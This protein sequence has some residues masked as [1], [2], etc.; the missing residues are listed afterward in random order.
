M[1]KFPVCLFLLFYWSSRLMASTITGTDTNYAGTE[2]IWLQSTDPFTGSE[3]ELSRALVGADGKFSFELP[4]SEVTYVYAY[5]GTDKV[6]L[7]VEPEKHYEAVLP[8]YQ[9][10][11]RSDK[12]NPFFRYT[13]AHLGISNAKHDDLNLQIRMFDDGFYPYYLKHTEK[14]FANDVEFLQLD[15]DIAQ[16]DKPFAKSTHTFFNDYRRYKYG[17]LRF[18]AYQHKSKSISDAYFKN[19]PFLANNPAYIELFNLVYEGYFDYF[20]RSDEGKQLAPAIQS[21]S[22]SAVVKVLEKDEVLQ[23]YTLLNMVLLKSLHSEFYDD[24]YSRSGML[25][26][27]DSL[28][29]IADNE[30]VKSTAMQIHSK[31][32]R[33][34]AGYT[35]PFFALYDTDSNLV[36]LEKFKGKFVYLNFCSCFSYTCLNEFVMLQNLYNKHKQYLEIVTIVPDD[37]LQ[38]VNNF[39]QRSGYQWTFLHFDNQPDVLQQYDVRAFPTYYL[40]DDEGKLSLSPAPTPAEEFEGR[41]FILLRA[42]G[43]L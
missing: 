32:T 14:V 4:V 35:P 8:F 26:L 42:K 29:A 1:N 9:P 2:I 18:V 43:I 37:D 34:M 19:Q 28:I 38:V 22:Y 15:K 20:S 12:L 21:K 23:P 33:L 24:N 13:E 25:I 31:V 11:S 3:K 39:I 16:L 7:F 10:K 17:L 5:L 36:T 41:L 30:V 40:I 27:L 6:F